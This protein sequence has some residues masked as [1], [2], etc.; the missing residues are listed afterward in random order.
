MA[1]ED[2]RKDERFPT[3]HEGLFCNLTRQGSAGTAIIKDL[4]SGGCSVESSQEVWSGDAVVLSADGEIFL[5][6]VIHSRQEGQKW[7]AGM[8]FERRISETDLRR[9]LSE[10]SAP[11][12]PGDHGTE[13][14]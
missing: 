14:V 5:G 10:Y 8:N 1:N 7:H 2:R 11:S 13:E 12:K 3:R 9:L 6:E 4:S